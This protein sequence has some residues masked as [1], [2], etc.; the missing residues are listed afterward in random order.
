MADD[1]RIG[2]VVT[3]N[4]DV[5]T[6][7]NNTAKLEAGVKKLADAYSR[8]D[9]SQAK[10][11]QGI[12]QLSNQYGKSE[13][14]LK[15]YASAL[16]KATEEQ[17]KATQAKKD[18]A[19]AQKQMDSIFALAAQKEKALAAAT[20]SAVK[21][22]IKALTLARREA[23]EMNK[24]YN[25]EQAIAAQK[26]KDAEKAASKALKD[27]LRAMTA[28]RS[29]A[30]EM[31]RRYDDKLRASI[32][33]ER[34]AAQEVKKAKDARRALR[35]E[36]KEGYAALVQYRA[37]R[38]RLSQAER[39]GIV[40]TQQA[41]A[42][43]KNLGVFLQ[44]GGRHMSRTGV[45]T[46]QAGYQVGDF[47]VQVQGGTNW[48]VAFG[49]Q[50]TQLV[51]SL[52]MLPSAV[53]AV[54][55]SIFGLT[56]SVGTMIAAAGILIPLIT[57]VGAYFMRTS[58][59]AKNA[60][61][62]LS[63]LEEEVKSLT[64]S[65]E[66]WG[67]AKEAA[68]MGISMEELT[69]KKNIQAARD[70]L[71]KLTKEL[72]TLYNQSSGEG[73]SEDLSPKGKR[74]KAEAKVAEAEKL[75]NDLLLKQDEE[76]LALFQEQ[77]KEL[78]NRAEIQK[79]SM[80][81]G[82]ESARVRAAERQ[83]EVDSFNASI[84]AQVTKGKLSTA[85]GFILKL[86]NQ[87]LS[88]QA[89]IIEL[90][91]INREKALEIQE[92]IIEA[93]KERG[94]AVKEIR[95]TLAEELVAQ[96]ERKALA[97]D[98]LAL[99]AVEM[100]YGKESAQYKKLEAEQARLAYIA[101]LSLKDIKGNN[102]KI[103]LEAYDAASDSVNAAENL[104]SILA[105]SEANAKGLADALKEAVSAMS[106]L[107][108]F[109]AG[110]DKALAVSIAKVQA[111]KSGADAAIAGTIAGMRVDLE[112]KISATSG[113][114]V[115]RSIVESMFGGDRAKISAI[116]ESE[117]KRKAIEEANRAAS[118]SSGG[119][120]K[121]DPASKAL[122]S[123]RQLVAT[124]D[125]VEAKTLKVEAA[126]K[127][128]TEAERLG[129]ITSQQSDEALK[130]YIKSLGDAKNPMLDLANTASQALSSAFMSIVDGSKSASDAFGDMART[131][132]KQA[133]E[134]AVINPIINS[135]FGGVS[136]FSMLP[137][138]FA[139]GGVFSGGGQV[140]AYASGGV[141]GGPTYFPMSGGKTGLMGEAGPEAIMPLKR[142]KDGKLGVATDGGGS[143]TVVVNQSF[144]FQANG[145]ESVKKIIAQAAPSISAMAQKGMMDQRR[146]GGSMKSTFG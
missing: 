90:A 97:E 86:N 117:T 56:L 85:Y 143:Q 60:K 8:G 131:I 107:M 139:D 34:A 66:D 27:E 75:L 138:F 41:A 106:S 33:A 51:G 3:G 121:E 70:E 1:I 77:R 19:Q 141:V 63:S 79:L 123:Y 29:E 122:E 61:K 84:D 43:Q 26:A 49:Q 57:A 65:I 137:S 14:V 4:K 92:A 119:G 36:F 12:K 52:Y 96:S 132:I 110:L 91:N 69:G 145:D 20:T 16:I 59:E 73:L 2:I 108:G 98:S 5:L 103:A 53:L 127:T 10:A 30:N 24:R 50:A 32:A 38:M 146:R 83:Q 47:L 134:M 17:K 11:L 76:R 126:R 115:D 95:K 46:Q 72:D 7:V 78:S 93:E 71:A 102:L 87:A 37:A 58:S 67:A 136:G 130:E 80:Q 125:E 100:Q 45:M 28:M 13:S 94:E 144:N 135:I 118:R 129:V 82:A 6:A 101:E 42:A 109:S 74:G 113:A 120:S 112:S 99:L 40:T 114:G 35:M 15:G 25:K 23:N 128:L 48:M 105:S 31:N 68:S 104:S 18:A 116:E 88:N 21:A 111:L 44:Q 9:L 39:D 142:G 89:G 55:T 140:K 81:Y 64:K 133:F 22:E 124:Y 62:E 54:S